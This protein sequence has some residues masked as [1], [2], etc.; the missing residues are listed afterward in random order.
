MNPETLIDYIARACA[1]VLVLSL[2]EFAH[3]FVAYK[4]G[5]PTAKWQGRLTLNPLKHFDPAGM[6]MFIFV[7]FGWAKPVPINPNNFRHYT[8]D[9]FLTAAAGVALNLLL[10]FLGYP[11]CILA[12]NHLTEPNYLFVF[13]NDFLLYFVLFNLTFCIFNLIPLYPLDGFRIW[14]ALDTRKGQAYRF[15]VQNGQYILMG[16]ILLNLLAE[17]MPFLAM[18]DLLGTYMGF[19]IDALLNLIDA[20]WR[21]FL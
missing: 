21:L 7:G 19:V 17:R 6:L 16:L 3:A 10:A 18:F 15:I 5:D 2:H 8:R 4:A 20:F 11:L 9:L 14:D 1:V 13:L 12:A